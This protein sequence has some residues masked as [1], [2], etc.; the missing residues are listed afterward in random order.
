[1]NNGLSDVLKN[2]FPNVIPAIKELNSN[3]APVCPN[4]LVGFT[5]A[6]G[7]FF[8]NTYKTNTKV[9]IGIQL[10]FSI[11]QHIRDEVLM[12]NLISNLDCGYIKKKNSLSIQLNRFCCYKI[13]WSIRC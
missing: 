8:V 3:Q 1:M 12:R 13:L 6:E 11:T 9:G 10:V 7:S 2:V 5:S 4:W